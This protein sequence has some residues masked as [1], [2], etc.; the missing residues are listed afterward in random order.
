MASTTTPSRSWLYSPVRYLWIRLRVHG[1]RASTT[2]LCRSWLHPPVRDLWIR[3]RIHGCRASTTALCRSW[4]YPP[5][6]DLWIR[7]LEAKITILYLQE[8]RKIR[9]FLFAGH[10]HK[11]DFRPVLCTVFPFLH[12]NIS[13]ELKIMFI[14]KF[15]KFSFACWTAQTELTCLSANQ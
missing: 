2:N 12:H 9:T 14:M 10:V 7:L 11:Q 4:L 15:S 8:F 13:V 5:V 3:L 1:W 6:R